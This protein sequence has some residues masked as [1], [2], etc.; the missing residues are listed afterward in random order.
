MSLTIEDA[1]EDTGLSQQQWD[2]A[3][4]DLQDPEVSQAEK[5]NLV[6]WW[7]HYLECHPNIFCVDCACQICPDDDPYGNH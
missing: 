1:V 5:E 4:E 2:D 7:E 6:C 3:T